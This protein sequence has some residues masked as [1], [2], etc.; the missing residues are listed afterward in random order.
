MC[1]VALVVVGRRGAGCP[2]EVGPGEGR[3]E[4]GRREGRG[5]GVKMRVEMGRKEEGE[6]EGEDRYKADYESLLFSPIYLYHSFNT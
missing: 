2:L 5:G 3:E 1:G 4:G 6:R